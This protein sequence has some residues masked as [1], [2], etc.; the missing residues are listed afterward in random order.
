MERDHVQA[1]VVGDASSW[2]VEDVS[3][4]M[5][6]GCEQD[7]AVQR[8][9]RVLGQKRDNLRGLRSDLHLRLDL[10]RDENLHAA[11]CAGYTGL[12]GRS[13]D[14][15]S[16]T[17]KAVAEEDRIRSLTWLLNHTRWP[18]VV[19]EMIFRENG[20][21]EGSEKDLTVTY[22]VGGERQNACVVRRGTLRETDE[23]SQRVLSV[24]ES[25]GRSL[26]EDERGQRTRKNTGEIE[27]KKGR[28]GREL[29]SDQLCRRKGG[30]ITR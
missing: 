21:G 2:L 29:A 27:S 16:T 15:H 24:P 12:E 7:M 1:I 18:D 4:H 3:P 10:D 9:R 20:V 11:D 28:G 5:E 30:M 23:E 17:P 14:E 25:D 8:N 22:S 19:P 6:A 13:L 26:R